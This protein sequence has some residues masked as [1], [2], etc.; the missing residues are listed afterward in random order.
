MGKS[1]FPSLSSFLNFNKKLPGPIFKDEHNG[2]RI[3]EFVG[4][5]PKMY[6]LVDKK[7]VI[8]NMAKEVP[9]NVV[10][11]G[12]RM[13]VKASICTNIYLRQRVRGTQ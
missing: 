6:C 11:N 10:I 12:E 9:R 7:H 8:Q 13:N 3:T 5:K 2:H 1:K 4:L